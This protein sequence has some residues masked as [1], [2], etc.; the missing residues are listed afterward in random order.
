VAPGQV[1]VLEAS[2]AAPAVAQALTAAGDALAARTGATEQVS[3]IVALPAADPRG[4]VFASAL[5][6][7]TI[8]S[9]V[10][11]AAVGIVVRVRPAWRQLV[12]LTVVAAV[13]GAGTYLIAQPFLG[14]L[15]HG[16]VGDWGAL[17]LTV[18]ALAA[19][20]AGFVALFG[21]AG[22][23]LAAALFV[24]VGNAFSAVTSAPE[25]LPGAVDHLGQWLPPGAG[26]SLL[27]ST[28]Y[29]GGHA[30]S[31]HLAILVAWIAFGAVAVVVGHHAPI[32]FAA[33]RPIP[34]AA[35]AAAVPDESMAGTAAV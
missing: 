12:A 6:P 31:G 25:L 34:G 4:Q 13:A 29:F 1:D 7:L 16:A 19:G 27:R 28:A 3:D 22:L 23:G 18:L 35:H 21:A 30:A 8:C 10:L 26:A 9:I 17:S 33:S 11:A 24:F 20:T 5:L 2:A 15:P 14:A 32:R